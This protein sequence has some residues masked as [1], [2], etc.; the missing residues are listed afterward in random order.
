MVR[1]APN[2]IR[3]GRK[4]FFRVYSPTGFLDR[5]TNPFRPYY[6]AAIFYSTYVR[7]FERRLLLDARYI[8]HWLDV[9]MSGKV[10]NDDLLQT[11]ESLIK[12]YASAK[13]LITSRIHAAL[14]ALGLNTPVIF[15]ANKEITSEASSFNTPGR[16]DGII[17]LFRVMNLE[18]GR[19]DTNDE[20]LTEHKKITAD[21]VI[22]NK[23]D[24]KKYADRLI[25]MAT[26][27]M[28]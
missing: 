22:Q 25:D 3:L 17:E 27:F 21:T 1:H 7:K 2:V 26:K 9:D 15:I 13:L 6:K 4:D 14:P 24:W 23:T 19:F 16:L 20:M 28:K 10:T 18:D 5:S 8:T 12:T 11:A